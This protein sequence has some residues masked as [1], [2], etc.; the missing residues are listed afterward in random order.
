MEQKI[1]NQFETSMKKLSRK[2]IQEE[3]ELNLEHMNN[4]EIYSYLTLQKAALVN[5]IEEKM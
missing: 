2:T 3:I 4:D 1:I 5:H